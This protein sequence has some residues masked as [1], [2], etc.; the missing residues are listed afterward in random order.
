MAASLSHRSLALAGTASL[1]AA[2]LLWRWRRHRCRRQPWDSFEALPDRSCVHTVK[3]E[4]PAVLYGEAAHGALNMWVADME[5]ACCG[6]IQR[7]IEERARHGTFGYTLQPREAWEAAGRWLVQKQGWQAAPEPSSF[8]FSASVVTSFAMVIE[9]L[10]SPGDRVVVMTPL[11]GPL[12][13]LVQATGRELVAHTLWPDTA[14]GREGRAGRLALELPRL[15]ASLQGA[16]L[17]L[18][19]SPHNPTVQPPT[20]APHGTARGTAHGTAR[21]MVLL[22]AA[23]CC[24]VVTP[25]A[26]PSVLKRAAHLTA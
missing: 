11:Y 26:H 16:A 24:L 7:E 5:L 13:R 15:E 22:G 9:S 4:L 18:L 10:T 23:W 2:G 3:H 12:H 21:R 25:C 8:V 14:A 1:L 6:R 17:L 20:Q 19:C